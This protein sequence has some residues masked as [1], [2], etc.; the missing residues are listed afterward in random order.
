[1]SMY[2][3][4]RMHMEDWQNQLMERAKQVGPAKALM[5]FHQVAVDFCDTYWTE[6][7]IEQQQGGV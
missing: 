3:D 1:M 4:D 2:G 5:E 7:E 6:R